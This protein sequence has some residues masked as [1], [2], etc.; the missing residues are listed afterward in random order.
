LDS[1]MCH[2][3][4]DMCRSA[5]KILKKNR[6]GWFCVIST[7]HFRIT[8]THERRKRATVICAY[9]TIAHIEK[10]WMEKKRRIRICRRKIQPTV[11]SIRFFFS[12][13][14]RAEK[15]FFNREKQV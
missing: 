11:F 5:K 12:F 7:L 3:A 9:R 1:V 10:D 15:C 14:W 4:L 13:N 2:R 6:F 8:H